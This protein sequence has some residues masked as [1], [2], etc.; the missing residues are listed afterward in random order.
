MIGLKALT[1]KTMPKRLKATDNK[2]VQ[3]NASKRDTVCHF[4]VCGASADDGR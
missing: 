2:D 3:Q 1:I 4:G